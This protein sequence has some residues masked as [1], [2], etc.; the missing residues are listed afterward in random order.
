MLSKTQ[1]NIKLMYPS[2][3]RYQNRRTRNTVVGTPYWL[4]PEMIIGTE[5]TEKI[6]VWA[7]AVMLTEMCVGEPPFMEYPPLNALYRINTEGL[8][9]LPSDFGE[10]LRDVF[11]CMSK[12][13]VK[14]RSSMEEL[15]KHRFVTQRSYAETL[16]QDLIHNTS[17]VNMKINNY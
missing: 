14:E 11:T 3:D 2:W 9:A 12:R 16:L 15:R 1:N 13:S 4:P 8:P 7:L 5:V 6:D 10:D 17:V